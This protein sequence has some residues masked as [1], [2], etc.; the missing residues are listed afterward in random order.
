MSDRTFRLLERHQ[1]F[2][3]LLRIAQ[4]RRWVDPVEIAQ[5]KKLKLMV[6]DRLSALA[7]GS[8]RINAAR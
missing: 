5:L 6:K 8:R 1:R 7:R 2:D 3:A 4:G